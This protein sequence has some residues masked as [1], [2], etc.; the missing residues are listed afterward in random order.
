MDNTARPRRSLV[1]I[2]LAV[3]M[4]VNALLLA[5]IL[6]VIIFAGITL[7]REIKKVNDRV[8]GFNSQVDGLGKK[9]DDFNSSVT[10]LNPFN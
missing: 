9:I 10:K 1:S 6:G 8:D 4:T 3:V 2:Y 5:T 7:S